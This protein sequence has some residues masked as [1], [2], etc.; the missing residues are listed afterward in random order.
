MAVADG[1]DSDESSSPSGGVRGEGC[2]FLPLRG[3]VEVTDER[4]GD[5]PPPST[6]SVRLRASATMT[7][8]L[9]SAEPR[10]S[11][12][13]QRQVGVFFFFFLQPR[14]GVWTLEY[15]AFCKQEAGI[16]AF[17][18]YTLL[19]LFLFQ[20]VHPPNTQDSKCL[21]FLLTDNLCSMHT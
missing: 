6:V 2:R 5:D 14:R 8:G 16:W 18:K 15:W 1:L 19:F 7:G 17:S 13:G 4:R 20:D 9:A 12:D 10:P 3:L 11:F 21:L